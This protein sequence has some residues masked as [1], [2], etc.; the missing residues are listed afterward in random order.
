[1]LNNPAKARRGIAARFCAENAGLA[2]APD[3]VVRPGIGISRNI[4]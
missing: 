4:V 1:M 2:G 3:V